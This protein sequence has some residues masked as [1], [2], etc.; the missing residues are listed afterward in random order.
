MPSTMSLRTLYS[1][2]GGSTAIATAS[3][4]T[5]TIVSPWSGNHDHEVAMAGARGVKQAVASAA[6][7]FKLYRHIPA[8]QRAEWLV[9]AAEQIEQATESI[10]TSAVVAIGK[11]RRAARFEVLRSAQLARACAAQLGQFGGEVLPLDASK[12]GIGLFGFTRRMPYGVIGAIT[13]FNAPANL[14]MQKVAPALAT[15]NAVVAKPAPEGMEIA[16]IIAECFA[17]AGLPAGL[18]NVVGGDKDEALAIAAHPGVSLISV[19]GGTAAGRAL[20]T[21]AGAKRFVA[22]LGGNSANIVCDDADLEDAVTR[23]VPSAF[24]ASGQQCIS[25]Q[26]VI[27]DTR[28]IE[29]FTRLFVDAA[30]R[31]KFGD[32]SEEATDLGPVVNTRAADR[33]MDMIED[34]ERAGGE[35]ILPPQRNGCVISPTI[36]LAPTPNAR[37]VREEVFG[38]VVIIMPANGLEDAIRIAND[39]DYGLQASYFTSNLSGAFRVI[40]E[41]NVGSVWVNEGSRFRLDQYPF[42]GVGAS[43]FGREGIRY[44]MEEYTQWKFGGIRFTAPNRNRS[45]TTEARK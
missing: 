45:T 25:A 31:L 38:P 12:A 6:E 20:A 7:S 39:C 18:F 22:E 28:V 24:D 4:R 19:T 23:I 40:D 44:A 42:G 37:I 1:W 21:A 10:I 13:P 43:G 5:L 36:I 34:A 8:A 27:V 16:L 33:I 9:S 3:G 35:L 30:K 17:K 26:R 15:G 29:H 11:P 14:L 32:P 2:I 41:L